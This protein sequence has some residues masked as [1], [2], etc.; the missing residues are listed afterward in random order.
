[1]NTVFIFILINF[2]VSFISDI[3]L[4]DLSTHYGIITSLRRYFYKQSIIKCGI[5][6]GI[7]IVVALLLNMI[8]SYFLFRFA[9]PNNLYKLLQFCILAFIIG[10]IIDVLIDKMKI[11]GD[12]LDSFYKEV[13]SGVSGA[14][15]FVFSIVISYFIQK[16]ILQIL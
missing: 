5:L 16:N 9:V 3:V 4:N 8:L 12:R 2:V 1:M 10:Y 14:S 13:G 7:T 6:A 15:A 11:F